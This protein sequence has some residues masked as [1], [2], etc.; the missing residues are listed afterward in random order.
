M[1]KNMEL[2]ELKDLWK[3][4]NQ[5]LEASIVLNEKLLR[6]MNMDKA[7]GEFDRLLRIS[8]LGRNLAL[9][10]AIISFLAA[11]FLFSEFEFSIPCI[12]AGL[13]MIWSFIDHMSIHKPDYYRIP[14]I[15]LQKSISKFRIHSSATAKY[16]ISIVLLWLIT[17]APVYIRVVFHKSIYA[18]LPALGI[19]VSISII[20]ITIT[21]AVSK[22]IYTKYESVLKQSESYLNE[23]MEFEKI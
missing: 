7:V 4:N 10:Y 12:I 22:S 21:I 5:K 15:E 9:V 2:D 17:I 6:K 13:A 14:I 19:S 18:S 1:I 23:I 20:L 11:A 3:E 16:D 8:I